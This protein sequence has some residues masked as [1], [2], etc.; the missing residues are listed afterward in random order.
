LRIA[1]AEYLAL[2]EPALNSI[3]IS[4]RIG[5]VTS[6]LDNEQGRTRQHGSKWLKA[7]KTS[8]SPEVELLF[9]KWFQAAEIDAKTLRNFH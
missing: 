5:S 6:E 4:A 8:F 1:S 9:H 7:V 2:L 3:L